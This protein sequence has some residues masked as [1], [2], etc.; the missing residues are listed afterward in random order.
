MSSSL[1]APFDLEK[2]QKI[3]QARLDG[4]ASFSVISAKIYDVFA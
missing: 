4:S 3:A 1:R 2:S